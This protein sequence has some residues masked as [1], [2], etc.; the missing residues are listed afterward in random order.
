[1]SDLNIDQKKTLSLQY[2]APDAVD[3]HLAQHRDRVACLV[4]FGNARPPCLKAGIPVLWVNT[5]VLGSDAVYEAWVCDEPVTSFQDDLIFGAGNE[6]VFFG[7]LSVRFAS[8]KDLSDTAQRAYSEIF[9]FLQRG[10]YPNLLKVWNYFP[11]ITAVESGIERYHSFCAGRHEAF[12][13]HSRKVE[14]S[15]SA[16]VLGSRAGALVIYFLA[17]RSSGV[18]IENPRQ[19]SA[20][21]Y[22]KQ[23][24]PRSPIFSRATMAFNGDSQ[25][26][27]ISGTA[28]IVGHVTVHPESV[29]LQTRETLANIRAVIGQAGAEGFKF[30]GF[31]S[32][33][34]LKVY[35][36]HAEHLGAV[37]EIIR[38]EFGMVR[39]MI[40]LQADICRM[41]LL[42]EIEAV[43]WSRAG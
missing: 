6:N 26:L 28:S 10:S 7:C 27:F 25:A 39:D 4:C 16:C 11:E 37:R 13:R 40:V 41:D 23:Y 3:A 21:N 24:G 35:V 18:Q 2:L 17:S 33:I 1:M 29:I 30:A 32:G 31:G 43:C 5:P 34:A 36:R 20:Y 14:G 38:E 22:P 19:I 15:P 8:A 12:V 42:M 9:D